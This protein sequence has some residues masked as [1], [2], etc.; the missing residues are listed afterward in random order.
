ME[1]YCVRVDFYSNGY[2]H[3]LS[4]TDSQN[5][6]TYYINFIK[7]HQHYFELEEFICVVGDVEYRLTYTYA[8]HKWTVERV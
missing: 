1:R 8:N 2:I 7:E 6:L 3:P 5:N 4:F